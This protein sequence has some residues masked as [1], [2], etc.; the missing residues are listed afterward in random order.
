[1]GGEV[2][3]VGLHTR[4]RTFLAHLLF[5]APH[6]SLTPSRRSTV[7]VKLLDDFEKPHGVLQSQRSQSRAYPAGIKHVNVSRGQGSASAEPLVSGVHGELGD[8]FLLWSAMRSQKSGCA[9]AIFL[10]VKVDAVAETLT[11]PGSLSRGMTCDGSR[12][13]APCGAM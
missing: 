8:T 6:L 11:A 13:S 2:E 9:R 4:D 3:A 7:A 5:P 1:M 10:C 12:S